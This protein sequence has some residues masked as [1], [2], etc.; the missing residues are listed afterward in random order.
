MRVLDAKGEQVGV[1][2]LPE[3]LKKA[4][5]AGV[6]LVEIAPLAKPP[7]VKIIEF[8][9]FKYREDKKLKKQKVKSA[10]LKEVRFSPFIGEAD[11]KTR[12]DRVKEFLED[13]HKVRIVVKFLGRQMGSKP[14]GYKLTERIL[15]EFT[16]E[17]NVDMEP[18]FLGRHLTMVISPLSAAKKAERQDKN[19]GNKN[20]ES[21]KNETK[22]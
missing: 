20:N 10:D 14:Y 11:Y 17:I 19:K 8:G 6:D 13:K 3:A 7:V 5:E 16:G 2:S 22:N 18:K 21:K 4:E 9:K 15:S 12:I 1:M